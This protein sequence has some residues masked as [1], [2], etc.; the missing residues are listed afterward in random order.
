MDDEI[1]DDVQ[2]SHRLEHDE[3]DSLREL[4]DQSDKTIDNDQD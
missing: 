1:I 2:H 4:D 3:H